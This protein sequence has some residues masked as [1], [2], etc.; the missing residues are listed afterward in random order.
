MS[1]DESDASGD[2][3]MAFM[4]DGMKR[5][6]TKEFSFESDGTGEFTVS[7]KMITGDPGHQQ[8]GQYLWPASAFNARWLL[9]HPEQFHLKDAESNEVTLVELGAGCGLSGLAASKLACV[10][11]LILT[12]Y[13][14]GAIELL[15]ENAA[16]NNSRRSG[17]EGEGD[18]EAF[19]AVEK[20]K[21]GAEMTPLLQAKVSASKQ[22]LVLGSDLIYCSTVCKPLFTSVRDLLALAPANEKNAFFLVSSFSLKDEI[23]ETAVA[24]YTSLGLEVNEVNALDVDAGQ[25]RCQI[26]TLAGK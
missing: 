18:E 19:I 6:D 16:G 3:P 8:S 17:G 25:C 22:L 21:W 11:S 12:D 15:E 13:D 24:S 26:F 9:A 7:L 20:L 14:Y 2:S 23:E 1:D 10:E 5:K 4:F